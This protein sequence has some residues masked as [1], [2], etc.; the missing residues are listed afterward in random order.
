MASSS[1]TLSNKERF[2]G[3]SRVSPTAA[4]N[5]YECFSRKHGLKIRVDVFLMKF[6]LLLTCAYKTLRVAL[7]HIVHDLGW[8][9]VAIMYVSS[10]WGESFAWE[11]SKE[12]ENVGLTVLGFRSFV[13]NDPTSIEEAVTD[14]KKS[15]ARIFVYCDSAANLN[16]GH[17]LVSAQQQGISGDGFVWIA[18]EEDK[19]AEQLLRKASKTTSTPIQHL[20]PNLRGWLNVGVDAGPYR[21]K[22]LLAL[23][24]P[25]MSKFLYHPVICPLGA[26]DL[27]C[28]LVGEVGLTVYAAFAYDVVWALVLGL[29]H[30]AAANQQSSVVKATSTARYI[31]EIEFDG[32]TGPVSFTD[33]GDRAL[34]SISY[35]IINYQPNVSMPRDSKIQDK[36]EWEKVKIVAQQIARWN[37]TSGVVHFATEEPTWPGGKD[38]WNHAPSDGTT[39]IEKN[40]ALFEAILACSAALMIVFC[41]TLIKFSTRVTLSEEEQL[42]VRQ[43]V[44][45]RELLMITEKDGYIVSNDKK[46]WWKSSARYVVI[47]KLQMEAAMRLSLLKDFNVSSF[48][49]FCVAIMDSGA[50][51]NFET[52]LIPVSP[53]ALKLKEWLILHASEVLKKVSVDSDLAE[54]N[55]HIDVKMRTHEL[56]AFF[57]E[58]IMRA[59]IW[60]EESL[61]FQKLKDITQSDIDLIAHECHCKVRELISEPDGTALCIFN[62]LPTAGELTQHG[63]DGRSRGGGWSEGVNLYQPLRQDDNEVRA[64]RYSDEDRAEQN[65][66][67]HPGMLMAQARCTDDETVYVSQVEILNSQLPMKPII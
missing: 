62:W 2:P 56:F 17:V 27:N 58:K 18:W 3:F 64:I 60:R 16:I 57:R 25:E 10:D 22:M 5:G 31:R 44:V 55:L 67:A 65:P 37:F 41:Q 45:L 42:E 32:A 12:A 39:W 66:E 34:R 8:R 63:H 23:S 30:A 13:Y 40:E 38:G 51:Q 15:G 4:T 43:T 6:L 33:T 11:I 1:T 14:M 59:R 49:A 50:L 54:D 46:P 19:D 36:A 35:W 20:R 28:P 52:V 29:V 7:A 47:P 53:Q 61:L 48:D 21:E 24:A 26:D 9:K